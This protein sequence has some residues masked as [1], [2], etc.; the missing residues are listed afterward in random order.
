MAERFGDYELQDRLGSGGMGAVYRAFWLPNKQVVALKRL[1]PGLEGDV[2]KRFLREIDVVSRLVHPNIVRVLDFGEVEGQP[3]LAMEVVVG[4]TLANRI[5]RR[6]IEGRA[7]V[8]I[9]EFY[10]IAGGLVSAL[11]YVHGRG[12]V[13]RD[14]KPA[15]LFVN[16]EGEAL[17]ADFGL[18]HV[19][20]A[21]RMTASGAVIGTPAYLA[22]EQI[23][24]SQIDVRTDLYQA[25]LMLFETLAGHIP[26]D[27]LDS[28]YAMA[29]ARLTK[30]MPPP[31]QWNPTVPTALDRVIL[32]CLAIEPADRY[33]TAAELRAALDG[34]R[35]GVV[36]KP[37]QSR[38][39]PIVPRPA[40][41]AAPAPAR[42]LAVLALAGA[43]VLAGGAVMWKYRPA[44]AAA[45]GPAGGTAQPGESAPDAV[46]VTV[47]PGSRD[48][49]FSFRS[50]EPATSRIELSGPAGKQVVTL[51]S[52][53]QTNHT[54]WVS[55]LTPETRYRFRVILRFDDGRS[56][57][58]QEQ[59]FQTG[60]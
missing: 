12:V 24:G 23:R 26:F 21:S 54:T 25:G 57:A 17:L 45:Q 38:R 34:T 22:P 28:G 29:T 56:L 48:A 1:H 16:G 51:G 2:R 41:P 18:A 32:R 58:S 8:T 31:S 36:E 46:S 10:R 42:P 6:E 52:S 60:K 40:E 47:E 39:L 55:A 53:A 27:D 20:A 33:Q 5:D 19:S 13:H 7:V 4:E 59:D 35:R 14:L 9:D 15:N 49:L 3:Y 43:L 11:D 50:A 37:L 44:P 30:P